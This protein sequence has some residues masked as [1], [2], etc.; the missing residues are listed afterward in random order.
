M[1]NLRPMLLST[2]GSSLTVNYVL[3]RYLTNNMN[4]EEKHHAHCILFFY[5][6]YL[7]K[8]S[9]AARKTLFISINLFASVSAMENLILASPTNSLKDL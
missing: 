5:D 9:S 6:S 8:T 3:Q 2:A 1:C 4:L 7:R